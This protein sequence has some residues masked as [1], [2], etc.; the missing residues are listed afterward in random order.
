MSKYGEL[1]YL[2]CSA[3]AVLALICLCLYVNKKYGIKKIETLRKIIT[4]IAFIATTYYMIGITKEEESL[5]LTICF[6]IF[7]FG[8]SYFCFTRFVYD[9]IMQGEYGKRLSSYLAYQILGIVMMELFII[10]S[11]NKL[12]IARFDL[13][14]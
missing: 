9:K 11:I 5:V 13:Y 4:A 14:V 6:W 1:L 10:G 12:F 3:I 8:S 7:V 2:I